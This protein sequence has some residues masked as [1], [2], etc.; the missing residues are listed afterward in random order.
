ML[1]GLHHRENSRGGVNQ[2]EEER[3]TKL[4]TIEAEISAGQRGQPQLS[5]SPEKKEEIKL[6]LQ[7]DIII[8]LTSIQR[9]HGDEAEEEETRGD[10]TGK[11]GSS[12]GG[13]M[14]L[15]VVLG[16]GCK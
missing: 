3:E 16:D 13:P 8:F 10:V 2:R 11:R 15:G 4:Y 6:K 9:S 1:V 14:S 12:R 7:Q 5:L